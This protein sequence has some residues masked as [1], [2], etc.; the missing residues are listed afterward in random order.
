MLDVFGVEVL[1]ELEHIGIVWAD[2]DDGVEVAVLLHGHVDA[3]MAV[4][5]QPNLI[6]P[7]TEIEARMN[8]TNFSPGV[9]SDKKTA[10]NP[11]RQEHAPSN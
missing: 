8:E 5:M 10:L 4:R 11:L 6:N 9:G 1:F 3:G 2:V 7:E